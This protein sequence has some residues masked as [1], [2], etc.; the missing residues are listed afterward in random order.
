MMATW[1]T[2]RPLVSTRSATMGRSQRSNRARG[3]PAV[4]GPWVPQIL[5]V[6]AAVA[7]AG[8]VM[9]LV[10]CGIVAGES[11]YDDQQPG[12]ALAAFGAVAVYVGGGLFIL[13]GRREVVRRRVVVFGPVPAAARAAITAPASSAVLIGGEGLT[14]YHRADCAMA[15][16]RGWPATT[17]AEHQDAGRQPCGVCRP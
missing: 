7:V 5:A 4:R 8:L 17:A 10:G 2:R 16:G 6:Y 15:V 13:A 11:T 12:I 1:R 3:N 9:L 14:R